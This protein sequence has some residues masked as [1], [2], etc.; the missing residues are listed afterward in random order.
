M[1]NQSLALVPALPLANSPASSLPPWSLGRRVA[2]RFAFVYLGLY[3]FPFPLTQLPKGEKIAEPWDWV[4]HHVVPWFGKH[5]L[6]ITRDISFTPN[7]S[8]DTTYDY[9]TLAA[10][11]LF[12]LV[13]TAV[14]SILDRRRP[15]YELG[16]TLLVIYTRYVLAATMAGFGFSKI[17][18]QQFS[19][20]TF[21]RLIQQYGDSSPMGLLWTFMGASVPYTIFAGTAELAG[22]ALLLFRRT[23][24]LGALVLLGVMGNVVLLNLCYDVP[25]KLYSSHLW[26]MAL[27]LT[28]PNMRRLYDFFI[29]Q[30]AI[31]P[32]PVDTPFVGKR[33]RWARPILKTAFIV[34]L[35]Y[36]QGY[37]QYQ[38]GKQYAAGPQG[39]MSGAWDVVSVTRDGRPA[40]PG[41]RRVVIT[42]GTFGYRQNDDR[43]QVFSLVDDGAK[44]TLTLTPFED[45]KAP[46]SIV[47]YARVGD[48]ATLDGTLDGKPL[49]LEL[50]YIDTS[51]SLLMTRGF[52]WINETPFNR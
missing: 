48:Q 21:L 24:L 52:H 17:F 29:R 49:H 1:D 39:A 40:E 11:L 8:G 23:T 31:Q 22:G 41:W 7:G 45:P 25:V 44:K 33:W 5:A 32:A 13:A 43:R 51:K 34:S 2:F 50:R 6:H 3:S 27:F 38:Q 10:S 15:R 14:W 26:L 20:P 36:Q 47:K 46:A 28:L 19:P 4:M 37:Q 18:V 9:V 16:W 42:N 35:V 12:A 30:R